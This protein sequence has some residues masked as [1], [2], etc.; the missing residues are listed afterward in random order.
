MNDNTEEQDLHW[1]FLRSAESEVRARMIVEMLES[2]GIPVLSQS[3]TA[4]VFG[5]GFGGPTPEGI[6]I[7]VPSN[8]LEQARKI[9]SEAP[10]L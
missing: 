3:P 5:Y 8:Q 6:R 7:L 10:E 2:A 9:V 4:G 1:E